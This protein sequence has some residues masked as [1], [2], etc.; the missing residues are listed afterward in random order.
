MPKIDKSIECERD[1]WLSD[2]EMKGKFKVTANSMGFLF[3]GDGNVLELDSD[4]GR[5]TLWIY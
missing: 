3:W 2:D 1:S 5:T 4:D